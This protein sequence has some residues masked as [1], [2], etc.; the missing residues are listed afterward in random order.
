M[1]IGDALSALTLLSLLWVLL[2]EQPER[3]R[4]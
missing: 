4:R 1:T 3:R 2:A